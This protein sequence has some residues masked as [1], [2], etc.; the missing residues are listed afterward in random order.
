LRVKLRSLASLGLAAALFTTGCPENTYP[1]GEKDAY[2]LTEYKVF[3]A[4]SKGQSEHDKAET[5][6]K[7]LADPNLPAEQRQQ[8]ITQLGDQAKKEKDE[9]DQLDK[10]RPI[11]RSILAILFGSPEHPSR[12]VSTATVSIKTAFDPGV[13]SVEEPSSPLDLGRR[14]YK[15]H[16]M[17]CHGFYGFGDGPTANFL[18]P[19]P[20]DF[21]FGKVKFTSTKGGMRAVHDD[22]V[23][24][25]AQGV[26][27]TMMPAFGPTDGVPRIGIFAGTAGPPG[28]DVDAVASYIEVLLMRGSIEQQLA[29]KWADDGELNADNAQGSVDQI[30][31]EWKDATDGVVASET[32]RVTD[33]EKSVRNGEILFG[34]LP[35]DKDKPGFGKA[36]CVKCHGF[37]GLGVDSPKED[38]AMPDQPNDYGLPSLP[39]NLTLGIYRGGRRPIDLYRRLDAGIKGTPMPGQHGNLT[40]DE[41]WNV[42]DYVYQLGMPKPEKPE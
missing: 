18:L 37:H 42:V 27:G 30:L 13:A 34:A 8:A 9:Q 1:A 38:Q 23:R 33:I 35:N 14:L 7:Q 21:R 3:Y 39:M 4:A 41:I 24:T 20:R 32:P 22:L 2:P 31:K 11:V 12:P 6:R 28:F 10:L 25:V 19:K 15:Q 17:H 16:C 40:S 26:Q 36:G 29:A 5:L